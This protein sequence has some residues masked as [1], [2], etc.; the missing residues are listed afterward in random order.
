MEKQKIV[1]ISFGGLNSGKVY[2]FSPN[3]IS[4]EK[5]DTVVVQTSLGLSVGKVSLI[6]AEVDANMLAEPLK[7]VVRKATEKD[8]ETLA[9]LKQKEIFALSEAKKMAFKLKLDMHIIS[10]E[11]LFDESKVIILFTADERV[12]FRELVKMLAGA[13]KTRIE[14]RQVGARDKAKILGGIGP[15]GR[16]LCCKCFLPDFEKVNIKMAKNQSVA[17]SPSNLNGLC[18]RL[19]CCLKYENEQYIQI[20]NKMPKINSKVSTKDGEG[21]VVFNDLLREIVSVKFQKSGDDSEIKDYPLLEVQ[22]FE[23]NE[24]TTC[25]GCPKNKNNQ[26]GMDNE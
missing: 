16:E 8:M 1:G 9:R 24:P 25:A 18:G 17:L 20:L 21:I 2:Y 6:D 15:C 26:D 4:L 3:N 5:G 7:N 14:L 22:I 23:K 10:A 12:D 13:L 11:Y 19:K